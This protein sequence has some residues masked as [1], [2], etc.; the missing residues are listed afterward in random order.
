MSPHLETVVQNPVFAAIET[1]GLRVAVMVV[2]FLLMALGG[3]LMACVDAP[4]GE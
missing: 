4:E 2:A 1:P 3:V